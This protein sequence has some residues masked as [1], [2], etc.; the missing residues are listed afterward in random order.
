VVAHR[1][2]IQVVG[3]DAASRIPGEALLQRRDGSA[4]AAGAVVDDT[5]GVR[6]EGRGAI[7]LHGP[8]G[9]RDGQLDRGGGRCSTASSAWPLAFRAAPRLL[10]TKRV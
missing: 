6:L 3:I 1:Q 5:E 8:F 10:W 2:E 4:V 7:E 9:Q